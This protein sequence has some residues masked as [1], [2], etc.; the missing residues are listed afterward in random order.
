MTITRQRKLTKT[1]IDKTTYDVAHD[2]M[3]KTS[4]TREILKRVP[5]VTVDGQDKIQV[6]GQSS[7]KIY[8]NGHRDPSFE[9]QN[10]S[11]VLKSIPASSIKKIEVITDPG[12]REDAEGT[13]YILNIVMREGTGMA[14]VMGTVSGSYDFMQEGANGNVYLMTQVGKLNTSI[15][16]GMADMKQEQLNESEYTYAATGNRQLTSTYSKPPV[17]VHFGNLNMSYDIDTL[18]LA[19]V[20]FGGFAYSVKAEAESTNTTLDGMGQTLSSFTDNLTTPK[21]KYYNL[22]GRFDLQH[23]TH[24]EG[25][26]MTLSYMLSTRRSHQLM[27]HQLTNMFGTGLGYDAYNNEQQRGAC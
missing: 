17:Q 5:M 25:E 8:R 24:R 1:E 7:F 27:Q 18:T 19:T 20:S 11:D 23:K 3:A 21:Y 15:T 6:K 10:V 16:Y 22:N 4:S 2:E 14:G 12:A 9:G 13:T 26:V